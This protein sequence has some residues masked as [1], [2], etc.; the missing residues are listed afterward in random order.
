MSKFPHTMHLLYLLHRNTF[1]AFNAE[2]LHRTTTKNIASKC[3]LFK[4]N[5][6][7]T[8]VI[9]YIIRPGRKCLLSHRCF[10]I[11]LTSWRCA[12]VQRTADNC[13]L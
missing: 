1:Q 2:L 12:V 3:K 7:S 10:P 11:V 6:Q 9:M 8:F 4:I 5:S 13:L